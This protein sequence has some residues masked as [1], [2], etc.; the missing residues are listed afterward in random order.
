[1]HYRKMMGCR[2]SYLC[3][4]L[5]HGKDSFAMLSSANAW[6]RMNARQNQRKTHGNEALTAK[7]SQN[8]R[9]STN[10]RQQGKPAHGKEK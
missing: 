7:T 2:A 8:A 9:Q 3:H 4:A 5:T 1:M 6:Q 10:A